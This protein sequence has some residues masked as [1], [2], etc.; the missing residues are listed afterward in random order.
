MKK[1]GGLVRELRRLMVALEAD[2]RERALRPDIAPNLK[3][4]YE[5][6]RGA[7][8]T[9]ETFNPWQDA[10]VT[11]AAAAWILGCV[12]VRF[13]EDNGLVTEAHLSG[14]G[15][16]L[17]EARERQQAYFQAHPTGSDR[18][19]LE[20][21]FRTAALLPGVGPL[22]DPRHNPLWHLPVSGDGATRL[23]EFFRRIDPDTGELVVDFFSQG[24]DTRFLGDLYQDL[25]ESA[26]ER[27]ALLQTP[28]FVEEF[29]LDRTLT[30]AI[31]AFGYEKVRLI[32]PTCGSGH[33]LLGAFRRLLKLWLKF[34]PGDNL[35]GLVQQ[36]LDQVYGVDL[37]PFATNIA[38]FRLLVAA[39]EA[40]GISRLADAPAFRLNL[41]TGDSLLHGR[42]WGQGREFQVGLYEDD[43]LRLYVY[44]A[45]DLPEL[46]RILGQ[47]YHAVA[48]NPPYI[49]VKDR[50]LNEA[51]RKRFGSCHRKYQLVA[52]FVERFFDLALAPS[53]D[54][55]EGAGFVGMIVSN[56]FM[57]REFGKKL[58]E[59]FIPHWD[60]TH[61]I[62]ASGA[63]IP[64]HGTPT[65]ILFGRNR[66]PVGA[67]VRTVMGIRG[68]PATPEDPAHGFVWTAILDQ[69]DRPGSQSPFISVSEVP[70]EA[71][72]HH[73]WSLGGGGAAELKKLL[74]K[75]FPVCLEDLIADIG[76]TTHTGEDEAF[77]F[78]F[79]S[80]RTLGIC[81]KCVP[82]I[83][84]E[85]VRDWSLYFQVV[86]IFPYNKTTG[87]PIPL[88]LSGA[89]GRL[90]FLLRTNLR[91]RRDFQQTPEQ[92][93]LRWFDHS[94]FFQARYKTPLSIAFAF[95]A[96]HNHFV[97]DRGG[98]VFKQSAPV[99]KLPPEAT[100]DD[101]IALLG[102]LNSSTACFWMKQ[103]FFCKGSTVDQRGARQTTV[104]FEDF[105]EHDGTKLQQFPVAS[106]KPLE[107]A[108]Q[109]DRL[110]SEQ[111]E[112]LPERVLAREGPSGAAL[113]RAREESARLRHRMIALQEE[114]DWRCYR[115][116]GLLDEDLNCSE[117]SP[118]EIQLGE[119]AFEI[120]LARKMATGEADTT[121]FERHGSTP[122][123]E[124]PAG[125]PSSYRAIV[126]RRIDAI[127]SNPEIALI[128]KP[129]FK[130]RWAGEPWEDLEQKAL[131][132]FLF[133]RMEAPDLWQEPRLQ[134]AS[135]LAD[136]LQRNPDFRAAAEL[137]SGRP[138][139]DLPTL[140]G[141]LLLEEGVPFLSQLRYTD[142][143][144]RKRTEW[145]NT[146][147]LQRQED[148]GETIPGGIP[149]PPK[150]DSKDFVR[151]S[152]WRLRGKLDVPKERFILYPGA[153]RQADPS[154]VLGWA[155]W[156]HLQ[157]AQALA[158][159]YEERRTQEG[160]LPPR[161]APLLA[162]LM[163][164]LPWLKQWHNDPDPE[165]GIRMGDFFATFL[166]EQAH[167]LGLP[168]SQLP[169]FCPAPA[170]SPGRRSRA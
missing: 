135:R 43:P 77:Y 55:P 84:G 40:A 51:Y 70:R 95:V 109:L 148:A 141:E 31:E 165:Y 151:S 34:R 102:L 54:Q 128:E 71:F 17:A 134:S 57:K 65:A 26:R 80:A 144:L 52:P 123:T 105:W 162:G 132:N 36:A 155:G 73:P 110:A 118:P 169:S 15:P 143:G 59:T 4:E 23:L 14:R 41:A 32:D 81:E 2:I 10:Q 76:R 1:A 7:G 67:T 83:Q 49:T 3:A 28:E 156:N 75:N 124:I 13:L 58:I 90:F 47:Q 27:Y 35:R 33:F 66:E 152:Y 9:G 136:H 98:K 114:L 20:S 126:Q 106:E 56:A 139:F 92:R 166:E 48:G 147:D 79:N 164:L 85:I 64:G 42:R 163:E 137:Y 122:I 22:F 121:W 153:E 5:K 103:V 157:Q 8:R 160:W 113:K 125:W 60:L 63:Y 99:I 150:Y 104:P 131:R 91:Q 69:V 24:L 94:M 68:E 100:E 18:D 145:E 62:D 111:R 97:L 167:L 89:V 112:H 29:I 45:E 168:L 161:L 21:V 142:S 46:D 133:D 138:D 158:A 38:R 170:A 12:F 93:G 146:W 127:E 108:R 129:E 86:T 44:G 39:L 61:V 140:V 159:Y 130:R 16:K 154:P 115:V 19:Y 72:H 116:Y 101:H 78:P 120:L 96:T 11:Q 107:L 53:Q 149:V 74:E 119:R 82:L 88:D 25:S 87:E 50:V 117:A 6:A 30:P 37:N